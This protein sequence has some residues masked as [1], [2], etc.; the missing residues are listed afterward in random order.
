M[1]G[2]PLFDGVR[3]ATKLLDL[4]QI[5]ADINTRALAELHQ[6]LG[7]ILRIGKHLVRCTLDQLDLGFG[8]R[9]LISAL[10]GNRGFCG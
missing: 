4:S 3:V 5:I 1:T 7:S 9:Q 8:L 6:D 2:R 10:F